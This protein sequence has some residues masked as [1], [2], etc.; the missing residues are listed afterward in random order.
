MFQSVFL[1]SNLAQ[2]DNCSG[3]LPF[4]SDGGVSFPANTDNGNFQPSGNS[5]SCGNGPWNTLYAQ[6][7]AAWYYLQISNAGNMG[8]TLT[9]TNNVDI[10]FALWGP[11]SSLS[12]AQSQCGSLPDPTDCSY[13]AQSTELVNINGAN[14][15]QVY[16][17]MIT[18]YSNLPTQINAM[19][20]SGSAATNCSIV[21]SCNANTGSVSISGSGAI[22]GNSVTLCNGQNV[23]LTSNDNYTLPDPAPGESSE[24]VYAIYNCAPPANPDLDPPGV[25]ACF[26]GVYWTSEDFNTA[27]AGNLNTNDGGIPQGFLDAGITG[28]NNTLWFVPVTIDDSDNSGNPNGAVNVDGDNDNCYD[29]GTPVSITYSIVPTINVISD[30]NPNTGNGSI[31]VFVDGSGTY[32]IS[33]TGAGNLTGGSTVSGSNGSFTING[34]SGGNTWSFTLTQ[35]GCS[36]PF[37]GSFICGP[38][39]CLIDAAIIVDPPATDF[40]NNQYPPGTTV[41]FCVDIGQYNQ[42]FI[43]FLHGIVPVMGSGWTNISSVTNPSVAANNESGSYW[44]WHVGN[45]VTHNNGTTSTADD[46]NITQ[47]GW[48]FHSINGPSGP[49][50]S[51]P[52]DPDNSWGDGCTLIYYPTTQAICS[53][54]PN[55]EWHAGLGCTGIYPGYLYVGASGTAYHIL[56]N[57]M[58]QTVCEN[59]NGIWYNPPGAGGD[60]CAFPGGDCYGNDQDGNGLQWYACWQATT[61]SSP[62]CLSN[63]SL[64]VQVVTYADGQTGNWTQAGCTGDQPINGPTSSI[65]CLADPTETTPASFCE[66]QNV[67]LTATNNSAVGTLYWF[68]T[69][70]SVTAIGTGASLNLGMLSAGPYTFY[71]EVNNNGCTSNRIPVVLTINPLPTIAIVNGN[72]SICSGNATPINLSAT[73]TN[74]SGAITWTANP[75]GAAGT[76]TSINV[77]P[78]MTTLYTVAASN[79]CGSTSAV[80]SVI[81]SPKPTANISGTD[82]LCDGNGSMSITLTGLA[83][84]TLTYTINGATPTTITINDTDPNYNSATGVY[85]LNNNTVGTYVITN[86]SDALCVGTYSGSATI[87][88][89]CA[90]ISSPSSI[91]TICVGGNPTAFTVN[92][93]AT[94]S[95]SISFVYF[96]TSQTGTSMY[97]GGTLLSNVTP[98]SGTASYDPGV[99]G[100]AGSLPNSAGTYYVYS[101]LNPTP[102]DPTCRPFQLIQVDVVN[103]TTPTFAA[104]GP[105]CSGDVIAAL[106][107]T[108]TNSIMGTWAPAINNTTTTTY[109]FTP[110]GGCATTTTLTITINPN[111]TPTFAAVGPYCSGDVIAALPTTST[112]SIMGT[113]AP[114]INNTTTTTY[115]FTPSG[116]CATT[117]TL[118]ITITPNVT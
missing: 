23:N 103:P 57:S 80:V 53:S 115:T 10:D 72:E 118:T 71:V 13:N 90:T 55:G 63:P 105:Y 6:P 58:T 17:L 20:T 52:T 61:T 34:L 73:V 101:I 16:L 109:T 64:S 116:G 75:G 2:S 113:W 100:T 65:C 15:G 11:F 59:L 3:A 81:V 104:V 98:V 1:S 117:T 93:S 78:T 32:T 99:L 35:G 77:N 94:A 30:C 112:N 36:T 40:P 12:A 85:T 84:W 106:P 44:Q 37:S 108:S 19:Q 114:A 31:E 49:L 56:D 95:N 33:E 83:P 21:T 28:T 102:L 22:S 29:T 68:D 4:C 50:P 42:S 76:G 9:N 48:W 110:S 67:I 51:V 27:N 7:N 8:I 60:L 25:D 89:C 26:S 96:S 86:L 97:T 14:V 39:I 41:K 82:D 74:Y 18:N 62:A 43:N 69:N 54:T 47:A 66:N 107:T 38:D 91:Q 5:Y 24:L 79:S 111:V 70:T 46:Y 87:S 92:T 45:T 88:S